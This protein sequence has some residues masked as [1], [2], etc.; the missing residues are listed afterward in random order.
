M[1]IRERCIQCALA[2]TPDNVRFVELRKNLTGRAYYEEGR[3]SSPKPVTRAALHV[4]LHECAH[5]VLHATKAQ[6]KGKPSHVREMECELWAT[7]RM[8]EAGIAVP[9]DMIRTGKLYVQQHMKRAKRIN[10]KAKAF[11]GPVPRKIWALTPIQADGLQY[12][13]RSH[14]CTEAEA[15]A[16]KDK[17]NA[18][19]GELEWHIGGEANVE[20]I[21]SRR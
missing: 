5:F 12:V 10:A 7:A 1:S 15:K 17:W 2:N 3:L 16:F 6:R 9:R 8:R 19:Y 18:R 14:F 21:F 13:V 11:A 20:E 4:F